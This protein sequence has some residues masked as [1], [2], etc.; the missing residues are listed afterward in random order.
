MRILKPDGWFVTQQVGQ[1]NLES[2]RT[3]FGTLGHAERRF[4][5]D[6]SSA[7]RVAAD[8]GLSLTDG[9]ESLAKTRY[10]D[11]RTV[12]YYLK[13]LAWDF[14]HFDPE[15]DLHRLENIAVLIAR[16]GVFEDTCHRFC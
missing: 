9:R 3:I 7:Q 13:V 1:R 2:L 15:A 16:D 10:H 8:A 4:D 11:I 12:V 6:L 5:W 14:P